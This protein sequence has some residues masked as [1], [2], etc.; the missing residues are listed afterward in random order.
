M[1]TYITYINNELCAFIKPLMQ[2][3]ISLIHQIDAPFHGHK[4]SLYKQNVLL[5]YK[6]I[7]LSQINTNRHKLIAF[8]LFISSTRIFYTL[9]VSQNTNL[10]FLHRKSYMDCSLFV[11]FLIF[12]IPMKWQESEGKSN[13]M[14]PQKDQPLWN[15][16][17][18]ILF[19]FY[20]II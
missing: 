2:S 14:P 4:I 5:L 15:E 16:E 13:N 20:N 12:I 1:F 10:N 11:L 7:L 8:L 6:A 19:S 18:F 9:S 3:I 17:T